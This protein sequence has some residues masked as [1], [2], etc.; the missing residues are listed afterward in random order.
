VRILFVGI[1][2]GLR[3][4]VVGH[5]FAGHSNRFWKLLH[6]SKLIPSRL[7][8]EQDRRLPEWGFGLT[9][10]VAR[11]SRGIDAL[12]PRDY[13][14]GTRIIPTNRCSRRFAGCGIW[15]VFSAQT[16]G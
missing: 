1:N 7:T 9:N 16:R 2:P 10:I 11:P 14:A 8:H 13:A 5:H 4:A 15:T 12:T 6:E 3:S